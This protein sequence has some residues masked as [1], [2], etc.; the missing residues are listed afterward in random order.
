M[1][2]QA[3]TVDLAVRVQLV[4]REVGILS[5]EHAEREVRRRLSEGER[6]NVTPE[7]LDWSLAVVVAGSG[8][9]ATLREKL[10]AEE[11]AP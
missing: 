7:L 8:R 2:D 6:P 3:Y 9:D 5:P 10:V 11:I 4:I 1:I